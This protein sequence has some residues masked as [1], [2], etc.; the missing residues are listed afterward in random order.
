MS[1]N[2]SHPSSKKLRWIISSMLLLVLVT[3]ASAVI[4]GRAGEIS[5]VNDLYWIT[6]GGD[7]RRDPV[8]VMQI[9]QQGTV[10]RPPTPVFNASQV[11]SE[12]GAAALRYQPD[13]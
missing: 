1:M 12:M 13:G 3:S 5:V 10:T 8:Y 11:G 9:D 7:D 2:I 6:F 4:T